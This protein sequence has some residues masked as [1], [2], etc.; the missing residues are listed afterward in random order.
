M[1]A[2]IVSDWPNPYRFHEDD[3]VPSRLTEEHRLSRPARYST[4]R[5]RT[6]RRADECS[7]VLSQARHPALVA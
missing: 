3:I 1:S 4:E 5:R 7:I 6:R 2:T